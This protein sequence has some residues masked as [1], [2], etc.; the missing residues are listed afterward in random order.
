LTTSSDGS[1]DLS[2]IRPN[3]TISGGKKYSLAIKVSLS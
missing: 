1:N 2:V 3:L